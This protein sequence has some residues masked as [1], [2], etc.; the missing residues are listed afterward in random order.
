MNDSDPSSPAIEAVIF[1]LDGVL[2]ST[3]EFHYRGWKQLAD[4]CGIP[5]TRADNE[6]CRGVSRMESLEVVLEKAES[7]YSDEQKAEMAERKNRYYRQMLEQLTP[8]DTL[9]G[10]RQM[11]EALRY[12]GIATAIA[13]SSR[14]A[15]TIADAVGLRELV[16]VLVDGNDITRSKP[17]PQ[18][19]EMAAERLGVAPEKCLVVEDAV[20]GVEAGLRAGM[21]VLGIGTAEALPEAP[22]CVTALDQITVEQMLDTRPAA[23]V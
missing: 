23:D 3:D 16:D 14:N 4:T 19:F 18:V 21:A 15:G 5:F 22:R 8:A 6:R 13:S 17:D 9:A 11:L 10:A 1:D 7:T 12:R 20:A 2:V